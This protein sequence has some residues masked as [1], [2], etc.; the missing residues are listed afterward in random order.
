MKYSHSRSCDF[1]VVD[2]S[3]KKSLAEI[4]E[5]IMVPT[6][7]KP[8]SETCPSAGM[9]PAKREYD[10]GANKAATPAVLTDGDQMTT[11]SLHS[12]GDDKHGFSIQIIEVFSIFFAFLKLSIVQITRQK[13]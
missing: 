2:S 11:L 3:K 5:H 6:G 12:F 8:V 1:Y 10:G 7:N 13:C 4:D 9:M